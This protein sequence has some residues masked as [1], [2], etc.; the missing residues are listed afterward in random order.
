MDHLH[1][2]DILVLATR[3]LQGLTVII[4][5]KWTQVENIQQ[6]GSHPHL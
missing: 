2:K 3:L 5:K 4:E 1:L 6:T